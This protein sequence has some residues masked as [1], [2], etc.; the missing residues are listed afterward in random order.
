MRAQREN[1]IKIKNKWKYWAT[2][3]VDGLISMTLMAK[4]YTERGDRN[5]I[6]HD[7]HY[8]AQNWTNES[9][10]S[11]Q[12]QYWLS[13]ADLDK[14]LSG[15]RDKNTGL[16][17]NDFFSFKQ[18]SLS[19]E[20]RSCNKTGY[21]TI[22]TVIYIMYPVL[23]A[24]CVFFRSCRAMPGSFLILVSVRFIFLMS[25]MILITNNL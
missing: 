9:W 20:I 19:I 11:K 17:A 12:V 5:R 22:E 8:Y 14:N 4:M 7:F 10:Q 23:E 6:S 13:G 3:D 18:V 15:F 2:N 1:K 24:C 16:T 21:L 25:S